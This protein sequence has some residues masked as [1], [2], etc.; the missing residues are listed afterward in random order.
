MDTKILDE[1][2]KII[3]KA[4]LD[5]YSEA[6]VTY[7]A[8]LNDA[9]V[10]ADDTKIEAAL[11]RKLVE[12]EAMLAKAGTA[13]TG[14]RGPREHG[15]NPNTQRFFINV[16]SFDGV[17]SESLKELIMKNCEGV[18]DTDFSDSYVK[19]KFSFFELPKDKVDVVM[20]KMNGIKVGEREVAVEL[21]EKKPSN[22]GSRRGG[23]SRGGNRGGR[24]GYSGGSR[25]GYSGGSRGGY[26]EGGYSSRGG[27]SRGGYRSDRSGSSSRDG[28]GRQNHGFGGGSNRY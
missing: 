1:I 20:E 8:S 24:G 10:E 17:N 18:N 6:I 25:G 15:E 27:S 3:E 28:S 7:K 16:G 2:T 11:L 14:S 13:S 21:S 5:E 22:G 12:D 9:G 23:F 26:S 19:D 4:N